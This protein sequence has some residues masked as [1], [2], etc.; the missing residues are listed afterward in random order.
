MLRLIA[1]FPYWFAQFFDV[2]GFGPPKVA[3][4]VGIAFRVVLVSHVRELL[5]GNPM[6]AD[7]IDLLQHLKGPLPC[8]HVKE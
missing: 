3:P 6:A 7:G 2:G 8:D 5:F 1:L 4:K